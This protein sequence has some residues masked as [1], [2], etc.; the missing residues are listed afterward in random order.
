MPASNATATTNPSEANTIDPAQ[1]EHTGRNSTSE[2]QAIQQNRSTIA[3]LREQLEQLTHGPSQQ[4]RVHHPR[5]VGKSKAPTKGK[6]SHGRS[7]RHKEVGRINMPCANSWQGCPCTSRVEGFD[8]CCRTCGQ[9]SV[10]ARD[11]HPYT[12]S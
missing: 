8:F 2:W 9:G 10:C 3:D 11:Y 1:E 4:G 6:S 5:K 7:K 12:S